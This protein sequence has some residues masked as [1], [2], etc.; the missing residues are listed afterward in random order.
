MKQQQRVAVV[1]GAADGL[2]L[3]LSELLG[4]R[5][6]QSAIFSSGLSA[7]LGELVGMG[8]ALWLS[9]ESG[10]GFLS[11]AGCG[12][13]TLLACVLPCIPYAFLHGVVALATALL[14]AA[15]LGAVVCRLRPEKGWKAIAET[16]G[17]LLV[18]G[19]ICYIAS[20]IH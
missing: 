10:N 11:A 4:L 12:V 9:S 17:V 16:Y 20:L 3:A 7:G 2:T 15:L 13:A 14:V 19:S 18:S 5:A 1:L 6:H 8:A